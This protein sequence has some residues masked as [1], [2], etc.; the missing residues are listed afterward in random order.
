MQQPTIFISYSHVDEAWKNQLVKQ[1]N[2]L[3]S[4][5]HFKVWDDR[6]I[7]AGDNW[8]P[9][10]EAAINTASVA[11]LLISADFL[12]SSFIRG[13]DVPRLLRRRAAQGLRV[14]PLIIRPCPWQRVDWLRGIQGRPTDG[15]PLAQ[16]NEYQIEADLTALVQEV[17]DLLQPLRQGPGSS[18]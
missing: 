4:E 8:Y 17:D 15:R 5:E 1:L 18:D 9:A 13:E 11:I 2:V 7:A 3:A 10:I 12:T 6:V 14:I 16:G